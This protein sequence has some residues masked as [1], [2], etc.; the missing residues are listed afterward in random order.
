[1]ERRRHLDVVYIQKTERRNEEVWE[2]ER[3]LGGG[4]GSNGDPPYSHSFT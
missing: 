4:R 2:G 1:M 3:G